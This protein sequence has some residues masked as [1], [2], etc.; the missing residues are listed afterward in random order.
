MSN[1]P[2]SLM[3]QPIDPRILEFRENILDVPSEKKDL[4]ARLA[5]AQASSHP[6]Q[7][8]KSDLLPAGKLKRVDLD[9]FNLTVDDADT[10]LLKRKGLLNAFSDPIQIRLSGIDSP[11]TSGHA[12]DP[13]AAVRINEDQPYGAEATKRYKAL[14]A[15]QK[16]I[17][18]FIDPSQQTYGRYLGFVTGDNG[19]NL[20]IEEARLGLA[21]ALPFGESSQELVSRTAV[22]E[23]QAQ[24][25]KN[26]S[27]LWGLSRY[28]AT[29]II[30][31]IIGQPITH[32]TLTRIDKLAGNLSLGAYESFLSELGNSSTLSPSQ[33]ELTKRMGY[34]LRKTNGT[35]KRA[36]NQREGLHPGS[37][38]MGAQS[39]RSISDFG[40]GY[41][42]KDQGTFNRRVAFV[43]SREHRSNFHRFTGLNL[44][45]S[46]YDPEEIVTLYHGTNEYFASNLV[47][48]Q[49]LTSSELSKLGYYGRPAD[50]IQFHK[51]HP[52][53][54]LHYARAQGG[55]PVIVRTRIKA[56]FVGLQNITDEH[57]IPFSLLQQGEHEILKGEDIS[58]NTGRLFREHAIDPRDANSGE[59]KERVVS[60]KFKSI[61]AEMAESVKSR[62]SLF[63]QKKQDR[64][65]DLIVQERKTN[66]SDTELIP[67]MPIGIVK[68]SEKQVSE[69][70]SGFLGP[71]QAMNSPI[72]DSSKFPVKETKTRADE[73]FA[74]YGKE[75]A[76]ATE[77]H[78]RYMKKAEEEYAKKTLI[79]E[80]S[81]ARESAEWAAER[82]KIIAE[83][84]TKAKLVVGAVGAG[85][86][87]MVLLC[88][89]NQIE[90][91]H[92]G[93]KE[94]L[95]VDQIH[96]HSEFG[97]GFLGKF[98]G[99]FKPAA[100]N[101]AVSVEK[102]ITRAVEDIKPW[103]KWQFSNENDFLNAV[104][105]TRKG[106]VMQQM[107]SAETRRIEQ[108]NTFVNM[109]EHIQD[110]LLPKLTPE[111]MP[112]NNENEFL[113]A[114][115][116]QQAKAARLKGNATNAG[117]RGRKARPITQ[118]SVGGDFIL[119]ALERERIYEERRLE[120]QLYGEFGDFRQDVEKVL[121]D[122]IPQNPTK[123]S[124]FSA[125][126]NSGSMAA[127]IRGNI[128]EFKKDFASR[129]DPLKNIASELL[130]SS[131]FGVALKSSKRIR[132]LG[133]GGFGETFL[134]EMDFGG[135]KI[136]I[137]V[138]QVPEA[139]KDLPMASRIMS[140]SQKALENEYSA[141]KEIGGDIM[142]SA[143][144]MH[145]GKLYM[146]YMPGKTLKEFAA[147]GEKVPD[148]LFASIEKQALSVSEK[149]YINEDLN[150]GNL[151]FDPASGRA[152]WIDFGSAKSGADPTW[153]FSKM[154]DVLA[155]QASD[156][157][158]IA[159]YTPTEGIHPNA[160][161]NTLGAMAIKN[162]TD[163]G[164]GWNS[165]RHLAQS[166]INN[167][168]RSNT[169][170]RNKKF[171]NSSKQSVGIGFRLA[172]QATKGHANYNSTKR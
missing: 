113:D 54:S 50:V 114:V 56:K 6:S 155:E 19:V 38:G 71:T 166:T 57:W 39:I 59:V 146:E 42:R 25:K 138:K 20:N 29:D 78:L 130:N 147:S 105:E 163:F 23:A 120:R 3:G 100:R 160:Q 149:G 51:K 108:A 98:I 88:S 91:I 153:S 13:L 70:H 32:N 28:Q 168:D 18:I 118:S 72:S 136:P 158:S 106:N 12:G 49:R 81:I 150:P 48:G 79:T 165:N 5:E 8:R 73:I 145:E 140:F 151:M 127:E 61:D 131:E 104:V 62:S 103:E 87:L 1:L 47:K 33:I 67:N 80:E 31:S 99:K 156:L 157:S 172:K 107:K 102:N 4:L 128:T 144:G 141:L 132:K 162:N 69:V 9:N 34:V 143:Y 7:F 97:S 26:K 125:M 86:G 126:P 43:L 46:G 74:K 41:I 167:I 77:K 84:N 24:A 16:R 121:N 36:Y 109:P 45:S 27:G 117:I 82:T 170:R 161:A 148:E 116:K 21:T 17:N 115:I 68:E 152:S 171:A 55:T 66:L 95:G 40:S 111:R 164:S 85:V 169:I 2:S 63:G 30:G 134:H 159:R 101:T 124:K 123:G 89:N 22:A 142:P 60:D 10:L 83:A 37:Q 15:A 119:E 64:L 65:H 94:S 129:W 139:M 154:Q 44:P 122:I 35:G 96:K 75:A 110:Y 137:V 135:K 11:E 92:P 53:D 93:T 112:Y 52:E 14:L 133:Q 90:G 58:P 76:E